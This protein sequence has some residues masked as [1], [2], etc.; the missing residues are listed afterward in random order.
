MNEEFRYLSK[1]FTEIND[2]PP[3]LVEN[4]ILS[5]KDEHEREKIKQTADTENVQAAAVPAKAASL[6]PPL[7]S[8]KEHSLEDLRIVL[9]QNLIF[10]IVCLAP[11]KQELFPCKDCSSK[12]CSDVCKELYSPYHKLWCGMD[13]P[14]IDFYKKRH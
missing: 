2:Y 10:C 11:I 12:V 9:L 13:S 6:N 4:I 5:V 7:D 3:R 8:W 14:K 1:V